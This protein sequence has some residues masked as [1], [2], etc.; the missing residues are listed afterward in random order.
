M[1]TW[2]D[3]FVKLKNIPQSRSKV[4]SKWTTKAFRTNL[5]KARLTGINKDVNTN[6]QQRM[7]QTSFNQILQSN[8]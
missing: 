2:C 7:E 5:K 6:I 3:N 8:I 1:R 4:T